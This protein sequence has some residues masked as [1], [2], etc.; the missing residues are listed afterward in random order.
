L[1]SYQKFNNESEIND[2]CYRVGILL[3]NDLAYT[4]RR[5]LEGINNYLIIIDIK[6]NK[7]LRLINIYRPFNQ[8]Y[9]VHPRT[10]FMNQL[11]LIKLVYTMNTVLLGDFNLGLAKKDLNHYAF[12]LYF[13]DMEDQ[14]GKVNLVQLEFLYLVENSKRHCSGINLRPCVQ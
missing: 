2:K 5:D 13:E 12:K 1:I 3:K 6:S 9:N 4:R 11:E 14:L 8:R 7:G 10:F